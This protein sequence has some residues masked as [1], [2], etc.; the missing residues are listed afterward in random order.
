M[1]S[2]KKKLAA[3]AMLFASVFGVKKSEAL[4]P[5]VNTQISKKN[6]LTVAPPTRKF[7]K[8][9]LLKI[10]IPSVAAFLITGGILTWALWPKNKDV[11]KTNPD[12][13]DP[14][15]PENIDDIN[16][17]DDANGG[18]KNI[19]PVLPININEIKKLRFDNIT[20]AAQ[21]FNALVQIADN[22]KFF[23]LTTHKVWFDTEKAM[24]DS[25]DVIQF[26][27]GISNNFKTED[28][29]NEHKK[30]F[31]TYNDKLDELK[32]QL[33]SIANDIGVKIETKQDCYKLIDE[34][35]DAKLN[36]LNSPDV[37]KRVRG[38]LGN[39]SCNP[40]MSNLERKYSSEEDYIIDQKLASSLCTHSINYENDENIKKLIAFEN[41]CEEIKKIFDDIEANKNAISK[42]CNFQT[43]DENLKNIIK[44]S[45]QFKEFF[46]PQIKIQNFKIL[47]N[48]E[49]KNN[50]QN[51]CFE[52][53]FY[54]SDNKKLWCRYNM[55][56][57][58]KKVEIAVEKQTQDISVQ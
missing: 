17:I 8:D 29:I 27:K 2:R 26:C 56:F 12:V 21:M 37:K 33:T 14:N 30:K 32:N 48:K 31:K 25:V 52:F 46:S 34:L 38:F 57:R 53:D 4:N 58:D 10:G 9:L 3:A 19:K 50:K 24:V 22:C 16:N 43:I 11:K 6:N 35:R 40:I 55:N 13:H 51:T 20:T 15:K 28:D 18:D 41:R 1:N 39:E 49:K 44:V 45:K 36:L 7:N 54:G 23:G 5:Q 42:K 47:F